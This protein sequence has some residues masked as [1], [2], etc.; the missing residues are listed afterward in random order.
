MAEAILNL[1]LMNIP[2]YYNISSPNVGAWIY[3]TKSGQLVWREENITAWSGGDH[4]EVG[5]G[6]VKQLFIE[7]DNA[8][9]RILIED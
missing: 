3:E 5:L 1:A 2:L 6:D 4:F 9:P 7:L 8:I